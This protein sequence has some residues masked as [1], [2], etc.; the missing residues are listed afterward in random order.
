MRS[1]RRRGSNDEEIAAGCHCSADSHRCGACATVPNG[2]GSNEHR[3]GRVPPG[4]CAAAR[5]HA[6]GERPP[7]AP[8][9]ASAAARLC[10]AAAPAVLRPRPDVLRAAAAPLSASE[11]LLPDAASA[12]A[13][14]EL[15]PLHARRRR[16]LRRSQLHRRHRPADRGRRRRLHRAPRLR[17]PPR[18]HPDVGHGRE[19][20]H[21]RHEADLARLRC[22][23]HRDFGE[24]GRA[25][26]LV[27][28]GIG[29]Q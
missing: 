19:H 8:A 20:R 5:L 17:P 7:A 16:R 24:L 28:E 14:A 27:H 29:E 25:R 10:G 18:T 1:F 13:F 22:R 23:L 2:A 15:P 11:L 12:A 6:S 4:L 9:R 3:A 26:R 21:A